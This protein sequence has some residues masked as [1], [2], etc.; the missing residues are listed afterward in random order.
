MDPIDLL[1]KEWNEHKSNAVTR[2]DFEALQKEWDNLQ[3]FD[4]IYLAV[5]TD[6]AGM[7][8]IHEIAERLGRHR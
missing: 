7:V 2:K 8:A 5:E 3:R 6:S 1:L 4:T